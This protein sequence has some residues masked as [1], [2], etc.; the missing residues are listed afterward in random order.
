MKI[1][2]IEDDRSILE[3]YTLKFESEGHTV[4]S[5][6][7]GEEGL[8][9]LSGVHPDVVLLDLMMPIMDG[10]T[11]LAK[12]RDTSWGKKLPVIILTNVSED[13]MPGSLKELEIS[14]YIIKASATPQIVLE[15]ALLAAKE[16]GDSE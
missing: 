8:R 6:V 10:A 9:L 2:I 16:K 1:A 12:V 4:H 7:N 15:K 5:A 11:M 3:M 13:E 14:N